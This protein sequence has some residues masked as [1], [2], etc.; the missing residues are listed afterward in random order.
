VRYSKSVSE[1][2]EETAPTGPLAAAVIGT[3][4]V[5]GAEADSLGHRAPGA[6]QI[7][8]YTSLAGAKAAILHREVYGALRPSPT[9]LLLVASAASP[10]VATLLQKTFTAA[11]Q[12]EGKSLVVRDLVPLPSSDSRGATTF[13]MLISL[14]VI[15][16]IGSA[17]IYL[18]GRHRTPPVHLA[19]MVALAVG[20]GLVAT[21]VTNVL[22]GAFHGHFLAVGGWRRCSCLRSACPLPPSWCSSACPGSQSGHSCSWSSA[23]P[24]P[25]A[26]RPPS[27]CPDSGELSA[28]SYHPVLR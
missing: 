16:I 12:A 6:Y 1:R 14:L 22:I 3:P 28:N 21:L 23:T 25:R 5:V 17:I 7:H 15:G 11:A 8:A 10:A 26:D 9:P 4:P 20:A 2:P 19:V 13:S 24:H 18:L 27:C